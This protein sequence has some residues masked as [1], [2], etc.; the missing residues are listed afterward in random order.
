[1]GRASLSQDR[2]PVV[3]LGVPMAINVRDVLRS[4]V[5]ARVLE[6]GAHVHIFSNAASDE[7]F[8]AEFR[9]PQVAIHP[10]ADPD[11]PA[12]IREDARLLRLHLLVLSLRCQTVEIMTR[13]ARRRQPV[14]RMGRALLGV[15]GRG[16]QNAILNWCRR[17]RAAVTPDLYG[18][19]FAQH[20]PDLVVGTRILT[21]TSPT[22]PSN[23][24]YL[25]RHL[26]VEAARRGIR[27]LALVASWD[28]LTTGGFFPVDIDA[29][30][31]WSREMKDQAT[32]IHGLPAERVHIT[33]AP[34]HDAYARPS[35]FTRDEFWRKLGVD[36]A[37]PVVVYATGT[38]GLIPNEPR[39]VEELMAALP[40]GV[41]FFL[42]LHQLDEPERY[43]HL[44]SESDVVEDQDLGPVSSGHANRVSAAT[45]RLHIDQAGK[46]PVGDFADRDF[47][48][49]ELERLADT[50]R[51]ADV[52]VNVASS[53]SLD[54]AALGTPVVV[55][56]YDAEP[57]TPYARSARRFY[58][59][60]HQLPVMSSGG[61]AR[62]QSPRDAVEAIQTYLDDPSVHS[63]E[64]AAMVEQ[65]CHVIDG[66]SAE[67]TA[68]VLLDQ[69]VIALSGRAI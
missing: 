34:Q 23:P 33:G 13:D 52:V 2:P 50:L 5:L 39:L 46:P 43:G 16:A 36:P 7:A 18:S 51:H 3:F 21:M 26:I 66:R 68:A 59:F 67:R 44:S 54:A 53:I 58:A 38:Q 11:D 42:R 31:V 32:T 10:L 22:A 24:R 40:V 25:D 37:R 6:S 29:I 48:A 56:D 4:G 45:P 49:D 8:I 19:L 30:T 35:R 64:R 41:Q 12:F 27:T 17:R 1:M 20:R 63:D 28:N 55:L 15:A 47:D 9:H 69:L 60:T 61:V 65:L 57:D 62:A 14:L